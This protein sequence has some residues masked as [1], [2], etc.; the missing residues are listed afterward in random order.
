MNEEYREYAEILQLAWPDW[1]IS[2]I[3][4]KGAFASVYRAS[5]RD[6]SDWEKDAAVKIIRIPNSDS[7]LDMIL[8]E[9]KTP[10]QAEMY[11]RDIVE[12]SLKEIRAMEELSG[13]TNIVTIFDYKVHKVPDRP[14]WYILI[15]MEYLQKV[16]PV[17]FCEEEI[18]RMGGDVC[19]ALSI[20]RKKNIVHR[21]VSLD[22]VFVHDGNYKLGDFGVAKVLESTI[23]T[24]HTVA[25]KPLYMAPEVYNATLEET[26]ID[27]AAKVDIYSLGIL[28]YRL[29]NQMRY[30]F[31]DTEQ[32]I[33]SKER[34]QAFRRRMIDNEELPAPK[35]ASPGLA[36]VILKACAAHPDKRYESAD[37]MKEDL[38]ALAEDR[39][40]SKPARPVWKAAV[41]TFAALAALAC[42]YLFLLKPVLFPEWT[43]WSEWSE[44][45]QTVTDPDQKQEEVK[46]QFEWT[47]VQ[48]PS[49]GAY[50]PGS[51]TEC[52][53]CK[54]AL[55]DDSVRRKQVTDD[56]TSLVLDGMSG[57]RL[58]DT[59]PYWYSGT[60][61]R[62]RYRDRIR[63]EKE[64]EP[65][66]ESAFCHDWY[67][68]TYE[69]SED[70]PGIVFKA[71]GG[72]EYFSVTSGEKMYVIDHRNGSTAGAKEASVEDGVLT[73]GVEK[74]TL[75]D[76]KL[77]CRYGPVTRTYSR[78]PQERQI[79]QDMSAMY[80]DS[81][82]P[83]HYNGTWTIIKYGM[84]NAFADAETMNIIGKAVI[85]DGKITVTWTR[86][87]KEKSFERTFDEEL[88]RGCLYTVVDDT[89][90]Y[91]VSLRKDHTILLN[92]GANQVQWVMRREHVID[93][94]TVHPDVPGFEQAFAE[95]EDWTV[96]EETRNELADLLFSAGVT[97][98]VDPAVIR[99]DGPFYLALIEKKAGY[100]VL[101]CEGTG[102]YKY[103]LLSVGRGVDQKT[104][105]PFVYYNWKDCFFSNLIDPEKTI[106][107]YD[108]D[109]ILKI[110]CGDKIW[111]VQIH[112]E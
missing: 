22:N 91:I 79:P 105:E 44:T 99:M 70:Y 15:R 18:I 33:S 25:G 66:G 76:G 56:S 32:E 39:D 90:S 48:C 72:R 61:T 58:F 103:Y 55:P 86:N 38:L 84:N 110:V 104:G 14:V 52:M 112:P 13:N 31:E 87:G 108:K 24:M 47:N 78:E 100:P 5:R 51:G 81:L 92:I 68:S 107:E 69:D 85:E 49:C 1:K 59:I 3:I 109:E 53:A 65:S 93:E 8:A 17:S 26:D 30:P 111:P 57:V 23:G 77:V 64:Q 106:A 83:E 28:M 34:M 2:E 27:S 63:E 9:G 7:D 96:S 82:R 37:A 62:Y 50:N 42:A 102:E 54:S 6:G 21:D 94:S 35:N 67:F 75:E 20:C 46:E 95:R 16:D 88:N 89:V 11:F 29:A 41:L 74:F 36:A 19:T 71:D 98:G 60:V 97:G 43:K 80:A 73:V 4:G 45:R 12:D 101:I 10:E 40:P